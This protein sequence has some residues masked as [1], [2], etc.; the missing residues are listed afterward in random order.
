MATDMDT[1]RSMYDVVKE[2]PIYDDPHVNDFYAK[3]VKDFT[4][5]DMINLMSWL[6][7]LF[8]NAYKAYADD[9]EYFDQHPNDFVNIVISAAH[10]FLP[11][12][13]EMAEE[14]LVEVEVI[15]VEEEA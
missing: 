12:I 6:G 1:S 5:Q 4:L 8:G 15:E 2:Y 11:I 3:A 7:N 10:E 9:K 14:G 13:Y